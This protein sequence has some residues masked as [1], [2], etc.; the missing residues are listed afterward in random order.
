MFYYSFK[1]TE[2]NPES[3]IP[4]YERLDE[5][6]WKILSIYRRKFNLVLACVAL[7]YEV[8]FYNTIDN[9]NTTVPYL[10][11]FSPATDILLFK[12]WIEYLKLLT[13]TVKRFAV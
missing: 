4:Y 3:F 10:K 7:T 2:E 5:S 13:E 8:N 11:D 6:G 9:N 1:I 12:K